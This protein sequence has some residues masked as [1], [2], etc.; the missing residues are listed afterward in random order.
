[1]VDPLL[2]QGLPPACCAGLRQRNKSELALFG[3]KTNVHSTGFYASD[4]KYREFYYPALQPG[5][6]Y[7]SFPEGSREELIDRIAPRIKAALAQLEAEHG[8]SPPPMAAAAREFATSQL[9]PS[10]LSCYWFKTLVAYAGLYFAPT[11]AEVPAEV[12]LV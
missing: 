3:L 2:A 11:A 12:K 6:H 1:M 8:E 9:S 4:E 7:L 5:V 10:A